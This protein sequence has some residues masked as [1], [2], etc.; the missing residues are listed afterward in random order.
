MSTSSSV[1]DRSSGAPPVDPRLR[2]RRIEVRRREGRRRL[3]RLLIALAV[4]VLCVGAWGA[5]RS[6]LLDVDHIEVE[7]VERG[8]ASEVVA[9]AGITRGD[10]LVELDLSAAS[11]SI[12][13]MPWVRSVEVTKGWRGTVRYRVIERR[14]V[15]VLAAADGSRWLVDDEGQVLAAA[16]APDLDTLPMVRGAA[17]PAPGDTIDPVDLPAVAV[18]VALSPGLAAWVDAIVVDDDGELWLDLV[19]SPEPGTGVEPGTTLDAARVRL[20]DARDLA[21]QLVGAETVL[22]RVELDCL[23]VID[24][25][26]G[27]APVVIRHADCGTG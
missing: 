4:T 15:A 22:A 16:G 21:A 19:E 7:G 23:A 5:S 20:G 12:A 10:P 3:R 14:P 8:D 17:V 2:A 25:R 27:A 24:A 6:P 26:V 13:Q 11:V 18:A 1:V 9:V